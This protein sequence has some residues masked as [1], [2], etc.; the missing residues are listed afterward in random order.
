MPGT[1]L[2]RWLWMTTAA[3]AA[4]LSRLPGAIQPHEDRSQY[5]RN[6][7]TECVHRSRGPQHRRADARSH[8]AGFFSRS[9][10][11]GTCAHP[12]SQRVHINEVAGNQQTGNG[13]GPILVS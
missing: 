4:L 10:L 5:I 11:L 6:K 8:D 13:K 3:K 2:A 7:E 12:R 1:I 9:T